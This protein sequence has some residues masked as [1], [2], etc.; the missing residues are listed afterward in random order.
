VSVVWLGAGLVA[1]ALVGGSPIAPLEA[2]G[3][4]LVGE[5]LEEGG[6]SGRVAL[7]GMTLTQLALI[8][9]AAAASWLLATYARPP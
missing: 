4:A 7:V 6:A 3:G 8:G 9:L 1:L 5:T 2:A